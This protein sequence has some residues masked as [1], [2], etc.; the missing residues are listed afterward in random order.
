MNKKRIWAIYGL[1]VT[2]II[3][4]ILIAE[5]VEKYNDKS[6]DWSNISD[7]SNITMSDILKYPD[8]PWDW[9]YIS[10]NQNITFDFVEKY[11]NTP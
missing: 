6:W 11:A 8:K 10:Y 1:L 3:A 9:G 4:F 2:L 7:N 5:F